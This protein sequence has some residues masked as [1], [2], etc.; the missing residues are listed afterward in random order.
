[1]PVKREAATLTSAVII[2]YAPMKEPCKI[3]IT[4]MQFEAMQRWDN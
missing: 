1:M 3:L 2:P 4:S